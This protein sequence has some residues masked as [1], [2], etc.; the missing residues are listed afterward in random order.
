MKRI[1]VISLLI[2]TSGAIVS[3][4]QS[5]STEEIEELKSQISNLRHTY[6]RIQKS[7]DDLLMFE[8]FGDVA[9]ID[10]VYLTGPPKPDRVEKN[11]TRQGYGNPFRFQAYVF[12]PRDI[13]PSKKYPL[14]VFLYV[15]DE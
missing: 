2:L 7:I 6:D 11:K 12:I 13:D 4:G 1:I 15:Y 5:S 14:L 3:F 8:R 10:K 9:F